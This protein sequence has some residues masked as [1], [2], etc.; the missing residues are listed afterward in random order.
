MA[1]T[2]DDPV[3]VDTNVL[4]YANTVRS[5]LHIQA[6]LALQRSVRIGNHTL[7]QPSAPAG[8]SGH[9]VAPADVFGARGPCRTGCGRCQVPDAVS[10][11]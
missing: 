2:A 9:S 1:T 8:V 5:P 11:R 3:F 7:D 10:Y 6:Q 4:V